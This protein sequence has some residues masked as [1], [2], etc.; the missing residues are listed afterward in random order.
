M[1]ASS[2]PTSTTTRASRWRRCPKVETVL[3]PSGDFWGGVGEPTIAVAAPAVNGIFAATGK[4]IPRAAVEGPAHQGVTDSAAKSHWHACRDVTISPL[5]ACSGE[6][7]RG[8]RVGHR[9][10]YLRRLANATASEGGM[11]GR[12]TTTPGSVERGRALITWQ[13]QT[14]LCLLCA[15][16]RRWTC[17]SRGDISTNLAGAGALGDA[18][19]VSESS[20]PG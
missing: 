15:I 20:T 14:S 12:W 5:P 1:A 19:C 2:R 18:S 9:D 16:R 10:R 7:G 3:V 13:R 6:H 11:V 8:H 17:R 4:R